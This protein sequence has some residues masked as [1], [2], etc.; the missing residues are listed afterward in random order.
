MVP[1]LLPLA[2]GR[3]GGGTPAEPI[4][5]H[6]VEKYKWRGGKHYYSENIY[7]SDFIVYGCIS[8]TLISF[9]SLNEF[10]CFASIKRAKKKCSSTFEGKVRVCI[11]IPALA[12]FVGL[13]QRFMLKRT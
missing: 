8:F 12:Q 7:M 2:P 1:N 13:I 9:C 4:R 3:P 11:T 6:R 5:F 10:S